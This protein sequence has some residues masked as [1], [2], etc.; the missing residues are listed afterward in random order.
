MIYLRHRQRRD[1]VLACDA[2]YHPIAEHVADHQPVV[3]LAFYLH[4]PQGVVGVFASPQGPVLFI[5]D[6]QWRWSDSWSISITTHLDQHHVCLSTPTQKSCWYSAITPIE[7]ADPWSVA[8]VDDFWLWLVAK[9]HD[10]EFI[11]IWTIKS[12]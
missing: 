9:R 1:V 3:P 10:A 2:H 6:Q 4:D 5:N 7:V 11:Q 8:A 12:R